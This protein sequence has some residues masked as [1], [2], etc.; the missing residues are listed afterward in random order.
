V[1]QAYRDYVQALFGFDAFIARLEPDDW[2]RSTP[3]TRWDVRKLIHH[4]GMVVWMTAEIARG[5]PGAVS[6][7]EAPDGVPTPISGVVFRP[8]LFSSYDGTAFL[9][10]ETRGAH[11][12][13]SA[14]RDG[15]MEA[16]DVPE[17]LSCETLSPW[18]HRRI[19]DWLGFVFYDLVVHTWDLAVAV[20]A[21]PHIEDKLAD[22]TYGALVAM[23]TRADLRSPGSLATPREAPP[24]TSTLERV[25][26]YCGRDPGWASEA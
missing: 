9:G 4:T 23:S 13:W 3:C 22:R 2:L 21:E 10:D 16:L 6:A 20:G 12:A 17:V 25:I 26:A 1:T 15:V 11:Q 19:D 5:R 7:A 24:D 18:G 8:S 14:L